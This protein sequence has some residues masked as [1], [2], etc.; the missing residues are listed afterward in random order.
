MKFVISY[1]LS[2]KPFMLKKTQLMAEIIFK[3]AEVILNNF[4]TLK[5]HISK[6]FIFNL[7]IY[8]ECVD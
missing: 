6:F 3:S 2:I 7:A 8:C 4:F 1:I 5:F